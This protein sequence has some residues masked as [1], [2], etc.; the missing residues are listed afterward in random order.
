MKHCLHLLVLHITRQNL[1]SVFVPLT[2]ITNHRFSNDTKWVK[3]DLTLA[4]H[5]TDGVEGR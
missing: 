2:I 3:F 5:D 1:L 4:Q